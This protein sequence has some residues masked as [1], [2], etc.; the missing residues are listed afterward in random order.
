MMGDILTERTLESDFST[1]DRAIRFDG[2]THRM[3]HCTKS[4]DFLV[5]WPDE[6]WFV[7][8]KDPSDPDIPE[9]YREPGQREFIEN[10]LIITDFEDGIFCPGGTS[11]NSPAIHCRVRDMN[12]SR[13][14]VGTTE[15]V[16]PTGLSDRLCKPPGNELPGYSR[17]SLRDRK[18]PPQNPL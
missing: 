14:P 15:S 13:S 11:E 7:E 8:V 5:E 16:V 1:A 4:V 12:I 10:I 17:M 9:Q 6:F 3:S 18:A 2:E